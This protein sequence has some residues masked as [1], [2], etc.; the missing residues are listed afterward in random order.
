MMGTWE[1][2]ILFGL[3][4]SKFYSF[5]NKKCGKNKLSGDPSRPGTV[6]EVLERA[7]CHGCIIVGG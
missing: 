6:A 2:I 3:F 1:L 4:L 5:H 7:A